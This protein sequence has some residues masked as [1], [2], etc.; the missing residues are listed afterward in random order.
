V[1]CV[2][3]DVP[4]PHPLESHGWDGGNVDS[5]VV[6]YVGVKSLDFV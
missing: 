5:Y 2:I 6:K 3:L 1:M 4:I